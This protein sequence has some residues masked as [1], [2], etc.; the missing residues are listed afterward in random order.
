MQEY[1]SAIL[2]ELPMIDRVKNNEEL[3]GAISEMLQ[4]LGKCSGAD[5]VYIFDKKEKN[6]KEYFCL[7]CEWK[8]EDDILEKE[9]LFS[10]IAVEDIPHWTDEL[11][12][13]LTI[14]IK[15]REELSPMEQEY[16]LMKKH[17]TYSRVLAPIFSRDHLSGFI[18]MDHFIKESQNCLFI[19]LRS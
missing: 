8:N 2:R 18:G 11:K 10:E 13:G 6:R 15:D 14:Q 4:L 5:R 9:Q 3:N 17:H 1:A 16:N 19:S 7:Q 12:K